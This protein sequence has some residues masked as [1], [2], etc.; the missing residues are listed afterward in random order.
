MKPILLHFSGAV[1]LS[2]TLAACIPAVDVPA[3]ST[4]SSGGPVPATSQSPQP[5]PASNPQ[6]PATTATPQPARAAPPSA[7]TSAQASLLAEM[8]DNWM[9]QP[10]TPGDWTYVQ[11]AGETFA[12][13]GANQQEMR[14][15]IRCDLNTR[16]VGIGIFGTSAR[17]LSLDIRT[18]T[19]GRTLQ[20]TQRESAQ[21]LL[22]AEVN[23]NDRLL[24]AMAVT[25]GNFALRVPG[26]PVLYLPGWA[27]V[28]RVIEDC[29]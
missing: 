24:D 18:E 22:A 9:D 1:A 15:I 20:A 16:K 8:P 19:M 2:F 10:R 23:A 26:S 13:Y 27:E 3:S 25:K 29:R 5:L 6:A 7:P 14:A 4:P 11:E 12:L 28:T 17:T 21:P